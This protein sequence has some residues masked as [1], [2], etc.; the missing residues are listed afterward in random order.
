M[1]AMVSTFVAIYW[2]AT[3]TAVLADSNEKSLCGKH[4]TILASCHLE[5][6]QK[7]VVSFCADTLGLTSYYFGANDKVETDVKFS[8]DRQLYRWVDV[9]THVT[10][11]GFDQG[12]H[13]YVLGIP[14]ETFGAK[15]FWF[16]KR[17]SEPLDF[18]ASAFC[19]QNSLGEKNMVTRT[20][21]DIEDKVVRDNKFIFPPAANASGVP[22]GLADGQP[23]NPELCSAQNL[24]DQSSYRCSDYSRNVAD[25]DLNVAY[26]RLNDIISKDYRSM[27]D[28]GGKLKLNI[29]RSQVAWIKLRDANCAVE[30]FVIEPGTQ[31]FETTKNHCLA[32]ES[33]ERSR[34]LNGLRF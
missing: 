6:A 7:K 34:Y 18:S 29:K 12:G 16:V 21:K 14:Q 11:L 24:S 28:L 17:S 5:R 19:T 31:A 32:R 30:V 9:D 33:A 25:E 15:A 4:E 8:T 13:S 10:F 2:V 1:K 3:S 20:I 22:V 23:V 26:K 27:P